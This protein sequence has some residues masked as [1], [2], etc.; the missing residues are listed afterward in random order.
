MINRAQM[1]AEARLSMRGRK[2][3]V[4]LVALAYYVIIYVLQVL[5]VK[6]QFPGLS[7]E[8]ILQ[9]GSDLVDVLTGELENAAI[10]WGG[11]TSVLR[12]VLNLAITLMSVVIGVGFTNYCLRIS[13]GQE[14]SFG[15]IFDTFGIFFKVI[16]LNILTG[17]FVWLWSLLFII[18]GIVAAYRYSLA[19]Y[20]LLDHPELS[21]LECIRRSKE[22]TGG[23]K[24]KLFV[25]D[26]SFIGWNIL[27]AIPFVSL[28][29]L[30]YTQV[31][32]ANY[33]NTLSAYRPEPE[34]NDAPGYD[35]T[36]DPWEM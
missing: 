23:H 15:D 25:L 21:A 3:S 16:W 14:A 1:K 31:T 19:V 10:Y 7:M 33:Y 2:P 36:R 24:G 22:L 4:Y 34:Q 30:P 27:T 5:A 29:V 35:N 6:L 18:P 11:K 12:N 26:L 28:F 32:W 8:S 20:V 13:R 9:Y 17:I